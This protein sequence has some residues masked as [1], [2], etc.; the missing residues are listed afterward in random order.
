MS[1]QVNCPFPKV[2]CGVWGLKR[3]FQ[4]VL[5][6]LF[7][8]IIQYLLTSSFSSSPPFY[9]FFYIFFSNMFW[10]EFISSMWPFQLA[11]LRSVVYTMLLPPWTLCN[12]SLLFTRAIQLILS[13]LL[14][15]D[16]SKR[17]R[18]FWSTLHHFIIN[19][20]EVN[21]RTKGLKVKLSI[22]RRGRVPSVSEDWFFQIL[23]LYGCEL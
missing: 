6:F 16:T 5:P 22:Y 9:S 18:Y 17:A 1:W 4:F 3:V 12:A 8:K 15:H 14:Q 7:L 13:I 19:I 2:F 23:R 10:Q 20:R 21:Q 11:A